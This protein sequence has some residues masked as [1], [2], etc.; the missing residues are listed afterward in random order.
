MGIETIGQNFK[1]HGNSEG[2]SH[3]TEMPMVVDSTMV[4]TIHSVVK[5]QCSISYINNKEKLHYY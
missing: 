5:Q 4:H 2:N 3:V 1:T